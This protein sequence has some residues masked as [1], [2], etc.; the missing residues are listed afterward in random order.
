[1]EYY[2]YTWAIC[3]GEHDAIEEILLKSVAQ[4][5]PTYYIIVFL[6]STTLEDKLQKLMNNFWWG[7]NTQT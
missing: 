5:I 6:L 7:S 4:T 3:H 2:Q 1:M